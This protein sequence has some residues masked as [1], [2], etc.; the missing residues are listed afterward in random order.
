M[1]RYSVGFVLGVLLFFQL[2]ELPGWDYLAV[3][4]ILLALALRLSRHGLL[5][6]VLVGFVW[7][8]AHAL[9][10]EPAFL[11][12]D[13]G[14]IK[15][16]VSGHVVSLPQ[17][18]G[19]MTRFVFEADMV[20]TDDRLIHRPFRFRLSW[21]DAP[22]IVAG[23]SLTL[24]VRLRAAHGFA[25]PGAWDYEGW[26]YWQ[27]IRYTG[28]VTANVSVSDATGQA[29]CWLLRLRQRLAEAI[30]GSNASA[31]AKAVI[32]ALTI[33]DTSGLDG[34]LKTLFRDTGTSHLMAISGLHVGMVAGIGLLLGSFVWRRIPSLCARI[35]A[36]LVGVVTGLVLATGYAVLAGMSLP[37]QR[38]LIM[39]L[40]LAAGTVLRQS[41]NPLNALALAA[42]G[43]LLWHPPSILSAGFWLSFCA[44][45]AIL[46]VL[47]WHRSASRLVM[48]IRL[49]LAISLV[50][51]PV[52]AAFGMTASAVAP[53][54]NLLVVPLFGLMIVPLSLL[55]VLLMPVLPAIGSVL[56][57]T[58]GR[59][60]DPVIGVLGA[61]AGSD[62]SF[63]SGT[64][65]DHWQ[66]VVLAVAVLWLL[67]PP[68]VPLRLLAIP[69]A[70]LIWLPV[71][72]TMAEGD[73]NVHVLDV[74]Q[75]LSTVVE[76]RRHV[77][78]FDTG[79]EY[80]SGFNTASAALVPFLQTLGHDSIDRLVLSHG[81]Q[82]HAG[83]VTELLRQMPARD[84]VSG[85][86]ARL[87]V[88]VRPCLE[89]ER[90]EWDGVDFRFLHPSPGVAY[91]GNNASCVLQISNTA[92][93]VLFTGDI[94]KGIERQLVKSL[95]AQLRSHMVVVPHH[96]S[97]SSSTTAFVS[98]TRPEWVVYSAGWANRYRFPASEVTR[99]WAA[100]DAEAINTALDGYIRL[101]YHADG[102]IEG[103]RGYR[104]SSQRRFWWHQPGSAEARHAVSSGD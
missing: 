63:T 11:P 83:G 57:E 32:K 34:D 42:V 91:D 71:M 76:T 17:Q 74:G 64:L 35:P 68:G 15:A 36:R 81:D 8:H 80:P 82:D 69:V 38:A 60:I 95:G 86:P 6:V 93:S 53:L 59:L 3:E 40:L 99:R 30:D 1:L 100:G 49:Q 97:R 101:E 14:V 37:T 39:L 16:L 92:G 85:E 89:G 102:H 51:W 58:A 67:A 9:I 73:Y 45:A 48:A 26:L 104:R 52:L 65:F 66:V 23:Q 46:A 79:P 72:P 56:L 12:G 25:N 50:L 78:V 43:V 103:P 62:L 33:G 61:I 70:G 87:D 10:T 90:W 31:Q 44:V 18:R 28:Y 77:L 7:S 19:P 29:C 5:I 55:G 41:G 94:E 96:G 54:V 75:G 13:D 4:V 47:A 24:P 2:T 88:A 20:D 22:L 27:G 98:A 21:R 84:I